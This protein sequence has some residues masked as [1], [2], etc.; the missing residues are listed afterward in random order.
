MIKTIFII[1]FIVSGFT[2]IWGMAGYNVS[3]KILDKVFSRRKLEKDYT[4][5]PFVTVLI[6]AHNEEKVIQKKLENVIINDYPSEK[7]EYII[8]SDHSTDETNNIVQ[9][10]I[11]KHAKL[12]ILLYNTKEH[13]GKTNAQNES[14]KFAKGEILVMTDANSM[15]EKNAIS[16]LTACFTSPDIAYVT[17]RLRYINSDDNTTAN[18]ESTY[19]ESDLNQR[20]IESKIYSI[21]AG[22]GAIYACRNELYHDFK[23]ILCHDSY[24]PYYYAG[25][26]KRSIYNSDA[27]ATE[28]AGEN[29][30]DEFKR[31]VRMNRNIFTSI[32][33]GI[34]SLNFLKYGWYSYFY[35]GHRTCRYL[36]WI[37]HL[38]VFITNMLLFQDSIIWKVFLILQ[39]L[40][41]FLGIVGMI[42]KSKNKVICLIYYYSMTVC[43]QWVGVYNVITGRAKPVWE[44][45]ESTR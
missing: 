9:A 41:Y 20:N 23:S 17:G 40:F 43:A 21:T 5:K 11:E 14:Q 24:M 1:L 31:K 33:M 19:W 35:F 2:I 3:L 28:K 15:F 45:A 44:K 13:G 25:L 27:C 39:I 38:V 34:K 42:T 36:L 8:A 32:K 10:F 18:S 37:S 7:I 30:S 16:E 26:K 4:N 12:N 22:N 6:V 29:V